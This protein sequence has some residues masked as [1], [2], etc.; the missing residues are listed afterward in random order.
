[1]QPMFLRRKGRDATQSYDNAPISKI[2]QTKDNKKCHETIL[3]RLQ[4]TLGRSVWETTATLR[5]LLPG[6]RAPTPRFSTAFM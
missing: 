5:V 3:Q 6:L 1:M 4:I 2:I